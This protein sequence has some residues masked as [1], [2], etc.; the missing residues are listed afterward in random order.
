MSAYF[1]TKRPRYVVLAAAK[2]GGILANRA[3]PV[4]FLDE[5][6]R[7]Q[8]N[9]MEAA[10]HQRTERLLFLGSSCVYPKFAHQPIKET[11][12]L[13][14]PLEK[15]NE[16][17]AI[18]KIAGIIQVQSV[19]QQH[20]LS[21]ISAMPSNLYGP[22]DNYSEAASHVL[23]SLIQRYHWAVKNGDRQVVN[24][25]TGAPRREF[26]HVDDLADACLFLMEHYDGAEQV[27][28]GTGSDVSI[29]EI[30]AIVARETGYAGATHGTQRSRTALRA[31]CSM[32]QNLTKQV[33]NRRSNW[34]MACGPLST[35][36]KATW[37]GFA[38]GP[39]ERE[40]ARTSTNNLARGRREGCPGRKIE[41]RKL[42]RLQRRQVNPTSRP[43]T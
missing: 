5:N 7:I 29:R 43:G 12:L 1:A 39:S 33:G 13:G 34:P 10:Q 19:R 2:V 14:G 42:R 16:S 24:W 6:L 23:P 17:Y 8:L 32:Y 37:D 4:E 3:H 41:S 22:N 18:A 30:A 28:V 15:T 26:L 27:N 20:N 40:L 21:W 31:R 36:T 25:G 11:E 38:E 9:V 35:G